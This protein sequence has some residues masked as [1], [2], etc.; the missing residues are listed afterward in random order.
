[1][2]DSL[3]V[4]WPSL[5]GPYVDEFG[6]IDKDIHEAAGEIWHWAAAYAIP[7]LG[8]EASGQ[9]ALKKVCAKITER[10]AAGAIQI[11]NLR[12]YIQTAFKH[13]VL[14]QLKRHR[15]TNVE[16]SA[17][18]K[19]DCGLPIDQKILVE[20]ILA[21]MDHED[22]RITELLILGYSFEEIARKDGRRSNVLRSRHSKLLKRIKKELNVSD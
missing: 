3:Q 20:Q 4:P 5:D 14:A 13:E 10:R 17:D 9:L 18:P 19:P 8:D 22:R 15:S 7:T 2:A 6:S 1:M 21:R 12:A 16:L 11:V